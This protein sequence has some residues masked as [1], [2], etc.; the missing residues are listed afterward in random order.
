M[1]DVAE[2]V[3]DDDPGRGHPDVRTR[4]AGANY[5]LLGNGLI[6][7]AV[8]HA[9]RGEGTA[10]GLLIMDPDHLRKKRDALTMHPGSGLETSVVH[11]RRSPLT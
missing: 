6:Q 8:Q 4:L 3:Y 1:V 9:P 10:L 11:L 2:H 5:F 7:A